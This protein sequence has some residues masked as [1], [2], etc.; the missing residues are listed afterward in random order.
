MR[1]TRHAYGVVV[2][3]PPPGM[4]LLNN[5]RDGVVLYKSSLETTGMARLCEHRTVELCG[6]LTLRRLMSCIYGAPFLMFLDHTQRR[7][8][9][10]MTPLDE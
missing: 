5:I 4:G 6:V 2:T 9:F 8:T 1:K 3:I 10:G 7:S